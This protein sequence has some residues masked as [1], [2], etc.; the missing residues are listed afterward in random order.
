MLNAPIK[1]REISFSVAMILDDV[2][3]DIVGAMERRG[4]EPV[5]AVDDDCCRV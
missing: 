2:M 3:G 5:D 4:R 1:R